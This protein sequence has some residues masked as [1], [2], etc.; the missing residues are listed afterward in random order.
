[1]LRYMIVFFVLAVSAGFLGFSGLAA[2][3]AF[4]ARFLAVLFVTLFVASLVYSVLTGRRVNPP[5]V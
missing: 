5:T 2:D 3:F 1:M 4:I